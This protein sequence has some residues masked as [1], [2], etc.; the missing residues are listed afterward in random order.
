MKYF[1]LIFLFILIALKGYSQ[2]QPTVSLDRADAYK[3]FIGRVLSTNNGASLAPSV[4]LNISDKSSLNIAL[5]LYPAGSQFYKYNK[6]LGYYEADTKNS[7]LID[8]KDFFFITG[9]ISSTDDY[10]P[11]ISKGIW[12]PDAEIGASYTRILFRSIKFYSK[13][14]VL[15]DV[16]PNPYNLAYIKPIDDM[17]IYA[18][19]Q[20]NFWWLNIRGVYKHST[21][22]LWDTINRSFESSVF[23]TI[24]KGAVLSANVNWYFYPS[25]FTAPGLAWY[26]QAGVD[27]SQ[28]GNN[29]SELDKVKGLISRTNTVNGVSF[30]EKIKEFDSRKYYSSKDSFK[31]SWSIDVPVRLTFLFNTP[32][33]KFYVG[34]GYYYNHKVWEKNSRNDMGFNINMPL[35]QK[36]ND[37][38]SIVNFQLQ[39]VWEDI[40]N[41]FKATEKAL[42]EYRKEKFKVGFTVAAPLMFS[43]RR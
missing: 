29:H 34:I 18:A 10:N 43:H 16:N 42:A 39:F 25:K 12:K 33:H 22:N 2:Q 13:E 38:E 1:H 30:Q 19:S 23:D 8:A 26:L 36:K 14:V 37:K 11:L 5:P 9:K 3:T 24:G 6:T 28:N 17:P 21:Y 41:K 15:G 32:D 40:N 27:Y 35:Q 7:K 4:V 31:L 20:I